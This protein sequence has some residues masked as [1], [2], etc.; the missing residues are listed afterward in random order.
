MEV[1]G[2]GFGRTGTMS[3]KASLEI[4]GLGPCYHMIEVFPRG[5]SAF[6][7]WEQASSGSPDWDAIFDG[8]SSTTDFPACTFWK[9]LADHYPRA[10][11]VLTV[12]DPE[13]WF[14][15]TQETI[16]APHWIEYLPNSMAG[17][18]MQGT[19]ND[20]FDGRMHDRDFLIQRFNEHV[21]DVQA[22]ISSERL[23]TF[24]VSQGWEPLCNFLEVPVPDVEFPRINDTE[25]TQ[26]IIREIMEKGFAGTF[27]Y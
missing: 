16:F 17:C 9:E 8:F 13:A 14:R 20:Y 3:L 19:I 15:S 2:V 26:G 27:G 4:L 5:P 1:I 25:A 12:R 23:L 21:A 18:F 6:P 24:E 11:L 10:K 22:N 7:L